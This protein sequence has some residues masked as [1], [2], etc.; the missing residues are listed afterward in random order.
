MIGQAPDYLRDQSTT[1]IRV[2]GRTTQNSQ[3]LN[4]PLY[5]SKAGQRNFYYRVVIIWNNIDPSL[6]I[7]QSL[8]SFK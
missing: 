5:K 1:T 8:T 3:F 2:T 7:L 6:K 4:V